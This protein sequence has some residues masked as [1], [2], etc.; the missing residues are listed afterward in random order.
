[1]I[2]RKA[3]SFL[4]VG[5]VMFTLSARAGGDRDRD[6][7]DRDHDHRVSNSPL[8]LLGT[9]SIP[10][11]PI[12]STDIAFVDQQTEMLLFA[13]RSNKAV[14]V[15]DA[16]NDIFLGRILTNAAATLH[17]TGVTS[18][19][20][21]GG[22]NGVVTT[23][24]KKVWAGDGDSTVKVADVDPSSPTY[25]QIIASISTAG[26]SSVSG[27]TGGVTGT[28]N[29]DDE[30]AYDPQHNI[31]IVAN[32]E[33]MGLAPFV[34]FIDASFPYTVLGQIN[35][36]AQG[37][38]AG[39][40]EQPV[41]D[42][43][44]HRFLLTLPVTNGTGTGAIAVINPTTEKVDRVISL[45]AFNCSPSGEALG[46]DQHIVVA[47]KIPGAAAPSP[48][49]FPLILDVSTGNE[50]GPGINQ[51]GGGDEV[52]YNPGDRRFVVASTV[53]GISTYPGVLGVINAE[54]GDWLQNL[55]SATPP[56]TGGLKTS[57]SAGN[58]AAF[59][60]NNHVFV[61]VK[62]STAPV[63]DICGTFAGVDYGCV[64]VFGP[65]HED[66]DPDQF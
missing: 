55:P 27:C 17:F 61:I 3:V 5:I 2:S 23:P 63:T 54:N 51:V 14:D 60:E 53:D 65:T 11:S 9:I 44:I 42:P 56:S 20:T 15:V 16:E 57:G 28:C 34:T 1:M 30:I 35:F 32:D 29:R 26:L 6:R 43:A 38:V 62:A 25:L 18:P 64:A 52:N 4:L 22:P 41:W 58:L 7:D 36:S 47:C 59:G 24:D 10:G 49:S 8:K 40:L 33:P 21:H 37:V 31:I 13:D 45:S 66:P 50:I 46:P 39:G 19:S 12:A 48:S